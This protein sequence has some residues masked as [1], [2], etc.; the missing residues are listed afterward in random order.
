VNTLLVG[1]IMFTDGGIALAVVRSLA[2]KLRG[3]KGFRLKLTDG[4]DH[5]FTRVA[6]QRM[7]PK[8]IADHLQRALPW[9]SKPAPPVRAVPR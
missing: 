9:S 2:R 7:L 1:H 8:M 5:T 4:A 6:S 3:A